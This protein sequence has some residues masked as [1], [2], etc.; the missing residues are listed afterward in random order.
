MT[1]TT[2]IDYSKTL[3]LPQTEFPMR[4]GLPQREPL[5]VERWEGMNLYKNF[6]S[7][8]KTAHFTYS[9]TVRPMLTATSIL[10]TR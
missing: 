7:R 5:F 3:Y 4:A 8:R 2:K 1:E 9:T 6:V 10:A